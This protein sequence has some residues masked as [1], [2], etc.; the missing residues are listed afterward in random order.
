VIAGFSVDQL[1]VYSKPVAA[2]L[3]GAFKR[4]TNVQLAADLF[5][6]NSLALISESGVSADDERPPDTRQVRGQARRRGPL[7]DGGAHMARSLQ[8]ALTLR[9]SNRMWRAAVLRCR[10]CS[11]ALAGPGTWPFV[12]DSP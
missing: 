2:A 12:L 6:I 8:D 10:F 3:L 4:V 5:E 7:V 9:G 1:Y 11:E